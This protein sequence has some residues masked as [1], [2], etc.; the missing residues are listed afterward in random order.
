MD[1]IAAL[2]AKSATGTNQSTEHNSA[3]DFVAEAKACPLA[4]GG[5]QTALLLDKA[6]HKDP[7]HHEARLLR[8]K[9]HRTFVP[10]WHFSMLADK[11]RNAAYA[12][13]IAAKVTKGDIVLDI[14]CGAGLTAMLAARAGAKHVYACEG[15]PL[16]AHAAMKIVAANGLSHRITIIPKWSY[17]LEVGVDLPEPADVVVSEIVDNVL[18]GEGALPTLKVAM[19]RL[20]KPSART[21]PETGTLFAQPIES[22]ELAALWQFGSAEGFDL[23]A[24]HDFANIVEMTPYEFRAANV[25]ALGAPT[26]LFSFDFAKPATRRGE[27]STE[28]ACDQKGCVHAVLA[29]FE[30]ILAP[31][32]RLSN[33]IGQA[34][35]WGRTAFLMGKP[36]HVERKD[37]V[38]ITASHDCAALNISIHNQAVRQSRIAPGVAA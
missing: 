17:D 14:G 16:I 8:E 22:A 20:A 28:L 12:K 4:D 1:R 19:A 3:D 29:S 33:G 30:M 37:Q 35:H 6:L 9:L 36:V 24:F 13:A 21:V 27:M 25:R 23:C 15:Q 7:H 2:R 38:E 26:P 34:G 11:P 18:L 10:R 32:I 5:L 31:D